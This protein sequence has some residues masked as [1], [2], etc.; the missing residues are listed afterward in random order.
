MNLYR[1][2]F[3]KVPVKRLLSTMSAW[4]QLRALPYLNFR[5]PA[6]AVCD[7]VQ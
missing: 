3:Y 2:D 6:A 5:K 4:R 1:C 7:T